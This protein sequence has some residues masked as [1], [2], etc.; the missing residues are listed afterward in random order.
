MIE[1][2]TEHLAVGKARM[3]MFVFSYSRVLVSA[4]CSDVL[5]TTG[6]DIHK[7]K[8]TKKTPTELIFYIQVYLWPAVPTG[9]E[10]LELVLMMW[11]STR[12]QNNKYTFLMMVL[13]QLNMNKIKGGGGKMPLRKE[14]VLAGVRIQTKQCHSYVYIAHP[15][16][17]G[18]NSSLKYLAL[19]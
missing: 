4:L 10:A 13:Q 6:T 7:I 14:I 16:P 8:T 9:M 5:P 1:I 15:L 17:H 2:T 19:R 3:A 12:T 11:A 18:A